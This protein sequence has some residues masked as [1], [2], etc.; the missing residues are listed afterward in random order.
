VK[1]A[2]VIPGAW[3]T[4]SLQGLQWNWSEQGGD[5]QNDWL[6]IANGVSEQI[7]L[8][9]E[10]DFV[11]ISSPFHDDPLESGVVIRRGYVAVRTANEF[12]SFD[13]SMSGNQAIFRQRAARTA[14]NRL[15]L[16]LQ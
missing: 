5:W 15:R 13:V 7:R 4:Q 6:K 3:N 16:I 9:R 2:N 12:L 1:S 10:V 8:N 14:L 11:L